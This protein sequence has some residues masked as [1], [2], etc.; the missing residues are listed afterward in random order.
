MANY[1]IIDCGSNTVRLCVYQ[2]RNDA[3]PPFRKR[4]M[5]T[6]LNH[7]TMAGL[8]SHVIDGSMTARGIDRAAETIRDHMQRAEYFGCKQLDVFATAFLRNCRNSAEAKT[9]IE[10][11]AGIGINLLSARDEAHL[12]YLGAACAE[13]D[14]REGVLIDIGGGS[15]EFTR[16]SKGRDSDNVSIPCGS[17]SSFSKQVAGIMPTPSEMER[18][19]LEFRTEAAQQAHYHGMHCATVYGIG[20]SIRGVAKIFGEMFCSGSKPACLTAEDVE[21]LL[22]VYRH[23]QNAFAHS[24]LQAVP[25]RIHTVV[26]GCLIAQ[27]ILRE[28]SAEDIRIC[29][30]GV[31]EGYLI[32]R[33]LSKHAGG[34]H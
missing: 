8:A 28:F 25:D 27:E 13:D 4:D 34:K 30:C 7:K 11:K 9:A 29:R 22:S 20:G 2:V 14:M 1:G 10:A 18:I 31:R 23:D 17:L 24:A 6:L 3:K 21:K 12:G 15:T 26:P 5:K 16:I 19:V 33:L 32:E